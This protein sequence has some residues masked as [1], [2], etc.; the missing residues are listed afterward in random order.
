MR[1]T[2]IFEMAKNVWRYNS[3]LTYKYLFDT[4]L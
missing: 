2:D 3:K 4:I 1:S